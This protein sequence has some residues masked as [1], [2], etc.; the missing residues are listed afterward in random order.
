MLSESN[1]FK[2]IAIVGSGISGLTAAHL[3]HPHYDITVFEAND[4]V[5][6]HSHTVDVS[7]AKQTFAVDTGF[8]VYNKKT[9]PN[10]CALLNKLNIVGEKSSMS[11][12]FSSA[13]FDLEYAATSFTALFAQKKNLC[14][15]NFYKLIRDII[16]FNQEAKKRLNNLD[17]TTTIGD[18]LTAGCYSHWFCEAYLKPM[19]AAIWSSPPEFVLSMPLN[20][21]LSFYANH[22]LLN[23][24]KRP[25]WYVIPGGSTHYVHRLIEPFQ[26]KIR[27]ATVVQRIKREKAHVAVVTDQGSHCFDAVVLACHSDEALKLLN[28]PSAEEQA[29]LSAIPYKMNKVVLHTDV[30]LMPQRNKA[31]ASWNYLHSD[32]NSATLTYYMN[33]LQNIVSK[34]PLLVTV[35]PCRPISEDKIL[36][37]YSYAH[38]QFDVIAEQAKIKHS[39]INNQQRTFYCGAYWY[40]GFHEDGVKSAL[41]ALNP[42]GVKL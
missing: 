1:N 36:E 17:D 32:G 22:G 29:V 37:Q 2:R 24:F 18:F 26:E 23:N 19:A 33:K 35:N 8:I 10:F 15:T 6:G 16:R 28:D 40:N 30:N 25:Q 9:Y 5:G 4:Y 13:Q 39:L 42:L 41:Q 11:F 14:R 38:P 27:L 34:I 31:W 12:S 21:L 7:V 20:F 3:L